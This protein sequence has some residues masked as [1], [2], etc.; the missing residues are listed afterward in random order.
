MGQR[1]KPMLGCERCPFLHRDIKSNIRRACRTTGRWLMCKPPFA[2][3]PLPSLLLA[4]KQQ[5]R[6]ARA[7]RLIIISLKSKSAPRRPLHS[8]ASKSPP[9]TCHMLAPLKTQPTHPRSH[10][11]NQTPLLTAK[12][13]QCRTTWQRCH[14]RSACSKEGCAP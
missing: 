13:Q 3:V 14:G 9:T 6:K 2:P 11:N 8:S 12:H 10:G 4:A 5:R 7:V 1:Q